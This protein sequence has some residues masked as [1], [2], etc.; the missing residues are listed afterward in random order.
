MT[1]AAMRE[2]IFQRALKVWRERACID[3]GCDDSAFDSHALTVVQRPAESK[4]KYIAIVGT[5]GT[6]TVMSVEEAWLEFART[7]HAEKHFLAFQ[8]Q[9]FMLPMLDEA[10]RRGVEVVARNPGLGFLPVEDMPAPALP[11][12][13]AVERWELDA[14]RPWASTFHNAL[15][16]NTDADDL[17]HLDEFRY[18]LALVDG[19]GTPVAMAGAWHESDGL[20]EI[21][22]DVA[23]DARGQRLAP[24]IVRT[25]ARSILD[26]GNIPTYYCAA[27]NVRSHRTALASGFTPAVSMGGIRPKSTQPAAVM[28]AAGG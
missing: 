3:F 27:T 6:G 14:C 8:P 24:V 19:T 17:E 5:L 15:W 10:R 18:A 22:V 1:T 11:A 4:E 28:S 26:S 7:L 21:G 20:I 13:L 12:G 25:M 9:Q 16:D 2:D 23:H